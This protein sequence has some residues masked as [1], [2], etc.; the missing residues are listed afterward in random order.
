[1]R[2][3]VL[4]IAVLVLVLQATAAPVLAQAADDLAWVPAD[5][6]GF[7]VLRVAELWKHDAFKELR[8]RLAK[9]DLDFARDFEKRVGLNPNEIDRLLILLPAP[10]ADQ[11][12]G[13]IIAASKPVK[14]K[15][16]AATMPKAV[17]KKYQGK[18]YYAEPSADPAA[19]APALH[20]INDQLLVLGKTERVLRLMQQVSQVK[21]GGLLKEGIAAARKNYPLVVCVNLDT[22]SKEMRRG[23]PPQIEAVLPLLD[24]RPAILTLVS[25]TNT[26]LSLE[27]TFSNEDQAKERAKVLKVAFDLA[28]QLVPIG[29]TELAKVGTQGEAQD[30]FVKWL[31]GPLNVFLEKADEGLKNAKVEVEGRSVRARLEFKVNVGT[32]TAILALLG[33][34]A[35]Q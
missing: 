19:K 24:A 26:T 9:A 7:V 32:L 18:S 1:M 3:T 15:V 31:V 10:G 22:W 34:A 28:R 25:D 2:R 33:N 4:I 5:T 12:L 16:L 8:E 14:S 23:F 11:D 13:F 35:F 20:A 27:L 21:V 29:R 30:G 17:E 6:P